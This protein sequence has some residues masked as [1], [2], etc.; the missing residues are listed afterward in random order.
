MT[1]LPNED[2]SVVAPPVDD[3][4]V[5]SHTGT[6][7]LMPTQRPEVVIGI[8]RHVVELREDTIGGLGFE[9][10]ELVDRPLRKRDFG[11]RI[12]H[13]GRAFACFVERDDLAA[14]TLAIALFD[15]ADRRR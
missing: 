2:L 14:F 11:A 15:T 10:V 5:V 12:T 3:H 1:D 9:I 8:P 6:I 7:P 13:P 4:S